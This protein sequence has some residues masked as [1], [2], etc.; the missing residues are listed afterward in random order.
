MKMKFKRISKSTLSVILAMMM[1]LS[2]M[3]I[4]MV[5]VNA[6][7]ITQWTIASYTI[8][9]NWNV[10]ESNTTIN[11]S[12]GSITVDTQQDLKQKDSNHIWF[13]VYANQNGWIVNKTPNSVV[14]ADAKYTLTWNSDSQ[15]Q[16]DYSKRYVTFKFETDGTNNYLTVSES[17]TGSSGSD[18]KYSLWDNTSK[19]SLGTFKTSDD[20]SFVLEK[21]LLADQP[22]SLYINDGDS[23]WRCASA[24]LSET[25]LSQELYDYNDTGVNDLVSFKTS[26][27]GTYK[28]TWV[29]GVDNRDDK[30]ILT[31]KYPD[32][33]PQNYSLIFGS[34][35]DTYG[36]VTVADASGN[37]VNS[38]DSVSSSTTVTFTAKPNTGYKVGGWYSDVNCTQQISGTSTA[39][40]YET[41]ITADTKVYVKFVEDSVVSASY[42]VIIQN[43]TIAMVESPSGSGLYHSVSSLN[44]GDWFKVRKTDNSTG[45]L[46]YTY[47]KSTAGDNSAQDVTNSPVQITNWQGDSTSYNSAFKNAWNKAAYLVYDSVNDTVYFTEETSGFSTIY[48]KDCSYN[49]DNAAILGLHCGE[50]VLLDADGNSI[51]PSSNDDTHKFKTYSIESGEEIIISTT[52]DANHYKGGEGYYVAGFVVNGETV[53]IINTKP[54]TDGSCTYYSN[55]YT[56]GEDSKIEITPV[57]FN[58]TIEKNKDYVYFTVDADDVPDNW[59]NTTAAYSYYYTGKYIDKGNGEQEPEAMMQDGTWPGQ[60]LLKTKTGVYWT[61]VSKFYYA[62]SSDGTKYEATDYKMSGLVFSNYGPDYVHS[63]VMGFSKVQTYDYNNPVVAIENGYDIISFTT[64]YRETTYNHDTDYKNAFDYGVYQNGWDEVKDYNNSESVDI[65]GNEVDST[66]EPIYIVSI[67]DVPGDIGKWSTEYYVHAKNSDGTYTFITSGAPST[68]ADVNSEQYEIM[69][70]DEYKGRPT[71][72]TFEKINDSRIDGFWQYEKQAELEIPVYLQAQYKDGE[73]WVYDHD[74]TAG[75]AT[76]DGV[77]PDERG[78]SSK[79]FHIGEEAKILATPKNG[80]VFDG[81]YLVDTTSSENPDD[82]LIT[83]LE[84]M[85]EPDAK[86]TVNRSAFLIA[87]FT[88]VPE[89][90]L[91]LTHTLLPGSGLGYYSIKAVVTHSDGTTNTYDVPSTISFNVAKTDTIDVTL[92]TRPAGFNVFDAWYGESDDGGFYPIAKYPDDIN[93]GASLDGKV[94]KYQCE[95]IYASDLFLGDKLLT[96]T[97]RYYSNITEVSSEAVLN[98]QYDDRFDG[99]K[100]YTKTVQLSAEY[101]ENNQYNMDTDDGR[102]IIMNNAPAVE[103]LYKDLKWEITNQTV[104]YSG[105]TVTLKAINLTKKYTLYV[106]N[107]GAPENLYDEG[108]K[109]NSLIDG[110]PKTEDNPHGFKIKADDTDSEGKSFSYW[111]VTKTNDPENREVSRT[112]SKYFNLRIV[113]NYTIT[114]VYGK[115]DNKNASIDDPTYTREQYTDNGKDFDYLYADFVLS[116]TSKD[117]TIIR[118]NPTRY[119]TGIILEFD[120]NIMITPPDAGEKVSFQGKKFDTSE[121]KIND[122][123]KNIN[124]GKFKTYDSDGDGTKNRAIYNYKIDTSLYNN[125]NRVDYYLRFNNTPN[126]QN[127][128]MKAYFYVVDNNTG[129][130][131]ISAPVYFNLYEIGNSEPNKG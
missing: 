36:S 114:A 54:N 116:Y 41:T 3:F 30:G 27:A 102:A 60:P 81:W 124:S 33:E 103:D 93:R 123:I 13:K 99:L 130:T 26:T 129:E 45:S 118:E 63:S 18:S 89:G 75:T 125:M 37:A 16:F 22:Y 48:A 64:K 96:N 97:I 61:M 40:I 72:I 7:D 127:Y 91:A 117:G 67:G 120:K 65:I 128:V 111:I 77:A 112:Y 9:G 49:N 58:K 15:L 110:D 71:Y 50:T 6:V 8:N 101:L 80:Y 76:V 59:G 68:F 21:D 31:V 5:S 84:T 115:E 23:N 10:G 19:T 88:P 51:T 109:Y 85:T 44:S 95:K 2:T 107:G 12:Y 105:T 24:G 94:Y 56:V 17:D 70:R 66:K 83:K 32:D 126:F 42:D 35:N 113:D 79:I 122:A 119:N 87:R 25:Q 100:T 38:G 4:G 78:I 131:T 34:N 90:Q 47:S 86:I 104:T 11:G 1:V 20:G 74:G 98:Y 69:N 52:V 46:V 108:I 28:F 57:Y 14:T 29:V 53:S 82:Y 73:N 92:S 106:S 62:E 43:S 121:D 39:E 55:N